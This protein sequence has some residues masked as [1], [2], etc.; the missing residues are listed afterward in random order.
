MQ[1]TSALF[2]SLLAAGAAKEYRYVIA[3]ETYGED[4]IVSA[5]ASAASMEKAAEIGRCMA[6]E[7]HLTLREPGAIPRMAQI[8]VQVRLNDGTRQSEWL[9]KG[10]YFVD[11]RAKDPFGTLTLNAF[12]PMLKAEQPYLELSELSQWPSPDSDVVDE[13][14]GLI[15]VTVDSRTVLAGYDVPI[16]EQDWTMRE[17]LGWIAASNGGN[18]VITGANE[19]RLIA[20]GGSTSLL[21]T[22][23]S[24]ALLLGDSIIVLS[25]GIRYEDTRDLL[26]EDD[27]A[28]IKF[29]NDFLV[30]NGPRDSRS[31]YL[32]TN[33]Q[34]IRKNA[35]SLQNLGLLRPFSGVKLWISHE[36]TYED[37]L[38]EE[39]VNGAIQLVPERVEVE[40]SVV[41]GD[42]TGRM[43][44]ADCPWATQEMVDAILANI[45]DY[46]YQGATVGGALVSPAVEL[47]DVCICD[48]VSFTVS[49]IREV[50]DALYAPTL[51]A[52]GDEEVDHEYHYETKTERQLARK[53]TLGENYYGFRVTRE[54]GIEVDNIVDGVVTTRMILNS[55]EQKFFDADGNLALYFDPVAGKY[56]FQGDV[57]V[58]PGYHVRSSAFAILPDNATDAQADALTVPTGFNLY[59]WS[60]NNQLFDFLL[61]DHTGETVNFSSP[62]GGNAKWDFEQT[63]IYGTAYYHGHTT[64]DAEIATLGDID[65]HPAQL[66]GISA[67]ARFEINGNVTKYLVFPSGFKFGF[68]Y[69]GTT[70]T[71]HDTK[72]G[73]YVIAS[74]TTSAININTIKATSYSGLSL[75]AVSNRTIKIVNPSGYMWF[76]VLM[77]WGGAPTMEDNP[78][79]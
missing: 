8:Q 31:S 19:L 53:V 28:A 27:T 57:I 76:G 4:Q 33:G 14:A 51:A 45:L 68:M 78:P 36:T 58:G 1:S 69:I 6:K 63:D 42:D 60:N 3:G 41:A 65:A 35:E 44:E 48:G 15:G 7:L 18:W 70:G 67:S 55:N 59:G 12:D 54:N 46:C 20:F 50:Y 22:D 9:D 47:G 25:T 21:G 73:M 75:E 49:Q 40:Q 2:K 5:E 66:P 10:T 39:S 77:N 79:T 30:L 29:G 17:V 64:S 32:G 38:V 71:N 62:T 72:T 52:P 24:H 43:L 37:R 61:I 23:S 74:P 56:K 11:T 16:P 26:G 13:I 34:D